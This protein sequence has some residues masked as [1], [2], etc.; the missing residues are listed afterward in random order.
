MMQ[1]L[2]HISADCFF[3]ALALVGVVFLLDC[4][5]LRAWIA[6][7]TRHDGKPKSSASKEYWRVH[8]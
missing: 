2:Y 5:G 7:L 4:L 6:W 3:A 1:T 8:E